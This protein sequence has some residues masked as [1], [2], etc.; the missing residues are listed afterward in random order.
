V[1]TQR[2][3]VRA[4]ASGSRVILPKPNI[5]R[6]KPRG[7]VMREADRKKRAAAPPPWRPP[8]PAMIA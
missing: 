3:A 5:V 8:L 4:S 6:W 7:P 1:A 2:S